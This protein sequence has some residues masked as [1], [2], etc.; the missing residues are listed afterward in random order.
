MKISTRLF[1]LVSGLALLLAS[2]G[3]VGLYGIDKANA[4][5]KTV[6]EYRTVPAVDL[7]QIDAL[8]F[9]SRMHVAQALANPTS[10]VIQL[11]IASIQ[12]NQAEIAKKWK[13]Y[14]STDLAPDEGRLADKFEVDY[15][16]YEEKAVMAAVAALKENDITDAQGA[17]IEKMTPMAVPVKNGIDALKQLQVD[18]AKTEFDHATTRF[19]VIRLAAL[20]AIVVGVLVAAL[21]GYWIVW[22]IYR[23][24]GAEPQE[25]NHFAER[26]G[27]G[28]LAVNVSLKP[29]DKGSLMFRLN[30]MQDSLGLVVKEVRHASESVASASSEIAQGNTNLSDRTEQQASALQQTAA[31]MAV[32]GTTVR[33]NSV[34]A[35]EANKLASTAS[36]IAEMGGEAVSQVVNTMR[37]IDESSH[38]IVDIISV[39]DG[40]AFQTNILALNAAVEAA[41]AGEQGRGFAVVAS[42]VRALAGRSAESAKEIKRLIG[43]SVERVEQ[44]TAL[45]NKAGDTM[46]EVVSSIKRVTQFMGEISAASSQQ[47]SGV[48]E[49]GEA[50]TQMDQMTQQNAALVEQMAAAASSLKSQAQDLVQVVAAFKLNE[51]DAGQF[52]AR[53]DVRT[54][55]PKQLTRAVVSALAFVPRQPLLN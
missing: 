38:K 17:M 33:I 55:S 21:F 9:S 46:T 47:A 7:G 8:V 50:V 29:D 5:L 54:P 10:E 12:A 48:S 41:R 24:L 49:V 6:Y 42:E 14:R 32:L 53:I 20:L 23:Q 18:V 31:S 2:V 40:I 11:S 3:S 4:S 35:M 1:I 30:T 37:E 27:A 39:I 16:T 15:T 43:A 19:N 22:S 51:T 45:V 13:A 36:A 26:V 44:G 25:A 52:S 28:D 34:R